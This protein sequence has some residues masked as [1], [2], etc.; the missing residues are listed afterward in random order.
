LSVNPH[1]PN[2]VEAEGNHHPASLVLLANG[3]GHQPAS[4]ATH[5]VASEGIRVT[6]EILFNYQRCHRRAFL[7]VYGDAKQCDPPSDYLLKLRQ[8]S[9][10]HQMEI[11]AGDPVNEPAY[12][13]HDWSAGSAATLALMQQGVDRIARGV[14]LN[15]LD[16]GVTL[17]SCPDLLIKQP[18]QSKFG[19]WMYVPVDIRLGKRPKM[20]YQV[21]A[22]FHAYVLAAVQESWSETSYLMLRQRGAYTVDLVELLPRMQDIL[23][24]CIQTLQQ[25]QE[26]EVFI[27]HNRCDLCQ[28]FSHCY[29][30]A[31]E[32]QHL[33]LLP[34][35][36]PTRYIYLKALRLTKLDD[37][38]IANPKHLESLPGFGSHVAHRLVKQAQST[39]YNQALA[40]TMATTSDQLS[41][42]PLLTAEEL[43]TEPVE[44][45]FDIE[46]APEQ[47]LIYLH[48]VLVV[49]RQTQ[50]ET[51]H[52]LLAENHQD[53]YSI[54][55]QFLD[56]VWRYP[57]APIFHFCPYE[58][59][60]VKR[61]AE[62]YG[63]PRHR[64]APLLDR[65]IDMHERVTRVAI[66]PVESYALK[67]IA[68]WLGFNWR[69]PNANGAQAICWY[70]QWLETGDRSFLDAILRYNEDDCR[71]TYQ[72]KDWLAT[73]VQ[74]D[75][76]A[77]QAKL[78]ADNR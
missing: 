4:A 78:I 64:V 52:A 54:W 44:L 62:L 67:P 66:L 15:E 45:Y 21:A 57:K 39:L 33:S 59:Q 53:E 16:D 22:A 49:D 19:D 42:S 30:V 46:S 7:D 35:V 1:R 70:A 73:F 69:D 10:A 38:A 25:E 68:R 74:S 65:F 3:N 61:L 48:G 14:L 17:I 55:E 24:G 60:T 32:R 12:P 56:L 20:D 63:T 71:A 6:N 31:Q 27:S 8:D 47:N 58:V 29:G 41:A 75:T 13:R 77:M 43:P 11:L 18:G 23:Q 34:G 2:L 36:T 9:L 26:P 37:L 5:K 40:H 76:Q 50:T 72:V 51:F 28:W